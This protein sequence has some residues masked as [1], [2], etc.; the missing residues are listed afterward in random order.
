MVNGLLLY[1]PSS[2][3]RDFSKKV[4]YVKKALSM[5]FD[6]L[7]YAAPSSAYEAFQR[8]QE[9]IGRYHS[10][11]VVGGDGAFN[12]AVNA[13]A[14]QKE[15]PI[16]GYI[17][18]G[19]LGDVGRN[20]GVGRRLRGALSIIAK[21]HHEEFDVGEC[22]GRYFAYMAAIGRYSDIAYAVS[23]REKK[24]I[25][26]LSYYKKAAHEAFVNQNVKIEIAF[27]D[28]TTFEEEVP[29]F[30]VLN[31]QNV[32]GF[33][34]NRQGNPFDGNMEAYITKKGPFGGLTHYLTGKG[35]RVVSFKKIA[36]KPLRNDLPWCLDGELGPF[37][38]AEILCHH[39]A[40]KIYCRCR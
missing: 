7:D 6:R 22:G 19:T 1:S 12:T 21:G 9:A 38:G 30:L 17:N 16:L 40:I 28:G 24:A 29:F 37:G 32:G 14:L 33:K 31:G 23:P 35:L 20:F 39:Q 25:G 36:V 18:E 10:L 13:L 8:E 5:S 3:H 4:D 26:K 34:V 15:A 11:I 27:E 2:G